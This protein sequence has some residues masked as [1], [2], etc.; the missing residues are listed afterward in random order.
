MMIFRYMTRFANVIAIFVVAQAI[1][2]LM[3]VHGLS[4]LY[5]PAGAI[6]VVLSVICALFVASGR[7]HPVYRL[8]WVTV[9][10]L[11]PI[12]GGVVYIFYNR[13]NFD[14]LVE[15]SHH[16]CLKRAQASLS[17]AAAPPLPDKTSELICAYLK[18]SVGFSPAIAHD[19]RYFAVGE[20]K[21]AHLLDSM[22]KAKKYIFLEY[23][24][25]EEG[26]IW[27]RIREVL[28]RK[29]A[30]GIDVRLICDGAGCLYPLPWGF[31]RSMAKLGVKVRMFNPVRWFVS[32]R[33]NARNHRKIASIDG[34]VAFCGG[35]NLADQYANVKE[36]YGHW[37]DSGV[38]VDGDTA[39]NMTLLFL[40]M[41]E[42]LSK[43]KEKVDYAEF[44]P[45]DM[46]ADA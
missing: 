13:R 6:L 31:V 40:S 5:L 1:F 39:W 2:F 4:K 46:C 33:I 30:E 24:I 45:D 38:M 36:M 3:L 19:C 21:I 29:A 15:K 44:M 32:A 34:K 17:N 11:L 9:I 41:W 35:L 7:S 10:M 8:A 28:A 26:L 42:F 22:E 27:D 14:R 43:G 20:E 12:F 37:K 23:F 18:N 16:R 25:I